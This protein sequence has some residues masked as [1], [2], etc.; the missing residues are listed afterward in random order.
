MSQGTSVRQSVVPA[1]ME[2][3]YSR[4]H[5]SPA[6]RAGG[7]LIISGQVGSDVDNTIPDGAAAQ[8]DVALANL[9][10]VLREAGLDYDRVVEINSFHVGD[11]GGHMP[12]FVEAIP[13]H[14]P[15]PYPAWTAVQVAGLAHPKLIVEV[16]AVAIA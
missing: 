12:H 11:M 10:R 5:F 14:F 4:L 16:K 3:M 2:R 15:E 9:G 13:K 1:S 6:I 8:I 7:L